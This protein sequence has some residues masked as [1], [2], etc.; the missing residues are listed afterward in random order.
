VDIC[1]A[2]VE[3]LIDASKAGVDI[4]FFAQANLLKIKN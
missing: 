2:A 4:T 3:L 1:H